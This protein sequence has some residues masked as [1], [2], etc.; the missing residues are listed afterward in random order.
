MVGDAIQAN[1]QKVRGCLLPLIEKASDETCGTEIRSVIW[2][3]AA[4]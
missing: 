2:H 3:G 4:V 1:S